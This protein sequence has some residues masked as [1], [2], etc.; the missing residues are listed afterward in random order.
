MIRR[1]SK[2]LATWCGRNIHWNPTASTGLAS[3][4]Q[5]EAQTRSATSSLVRKCW[6]APY[7]VSYTHLRA[8]ETR[9]H[10]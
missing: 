3:T 9:R 6:R 8:H 10:L 2:S 5:V 4:K 7:T 1:A